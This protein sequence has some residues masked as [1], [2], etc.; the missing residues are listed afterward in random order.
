MIVVFAV[1]V[2]WVRADQRASSRL[3]EVVRASV[4]RVQAGAAVPSWASKE[5]IAYKCGDEL[6]LTRP[7]GSATRSLLRVGPSPQWDPAFS[8]DGRMVAF[9]GYYALG[10]GAYALY[11]ARTGGCGV[12][13]LTRS[14]AEGPSWSLDGKWIAFDTSG[15]GTIWK[16]HSNGSGLTRIVG[17]QGANYDSSPAWSPDGK[18]IAFIHYKHGHGQIWLVAADGGK[19][20]L[21]HADAE[22][23]DE[24]PTWSRDGSR[25]AF[26]VQVWPRSWIDVMNADGTNAQTLTNKHGDAWNPVWLPRDTGIAF[27]SPPSNTGT[28]FAIRPDGSHQ[29][30]IA[31]PGTEQFTWVDAPLAKPC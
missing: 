3:A 13:R 5:F 29:Q 1:S 15:E 27:L 26:A 10:D 24:Q 20:R 16:L 28:L 14:I 18:T 9:R 25:I 21:L 8:P 19:P 4:A 31:L 17:A 12:H 6:C 23:S 7:D 22:A 30:R 2:S 11:V